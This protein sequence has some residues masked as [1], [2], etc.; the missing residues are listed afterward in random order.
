MEEMKIIY[1][2]K[3]SKESAALKKVHE[4]YQQVLIERD[5]KMALLAPEMER[6]REQMIIEVMEETGMTRDELLEEWK[7]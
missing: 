2:T 1:F 4:Y 6:Q 7:K 3:Y 5:I